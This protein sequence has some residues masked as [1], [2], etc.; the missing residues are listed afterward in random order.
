MMAMAMVM[1]WSCQEKDG[2]EAAAPGKVELAGSVTDGQIAVGPDGG[3][4]QVNVTSSEDWR[5]SGI[6]DWVTVSA[7][8]GKVFRNKRCHFALLH[9]LNKTLECRAVETHT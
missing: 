5:V 9:H 8:S 4:F 3:E 6:S 2:P 1:L 7:E